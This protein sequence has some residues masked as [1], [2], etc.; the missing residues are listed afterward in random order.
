[1][2]FAIVMTGELPDG[3]GIEAAIAAIDPSVAIDIAPEE[4]R[5]R[6]STVIGAIE[7]V[8]LL[9]LAG[10]SATLDE[11]TQVQSI[12]CGGCSG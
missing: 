2:E 5:L 11:V 1:M 6:V 4:G 9:R 3:R 12:C 8:A 10:I 7:L